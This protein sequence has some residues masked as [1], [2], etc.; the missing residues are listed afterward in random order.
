MVLSPETSDFLAFPA[1]EHSLAIDSI[2]V[3]VAFE[4]LSVGE[5]KQSLAFFE[6][7]M[8]PA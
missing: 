4:D 6:V 7:V 1:R 5:D 8:E 3:E 2:S